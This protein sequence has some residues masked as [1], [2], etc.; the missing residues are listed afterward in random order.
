MKIE[1]VEGIFEV[2]ADQDGR[3]YIKDEKTDIE[4]EVKVIEVGAQGDIGL[5]FDS[6]EHTK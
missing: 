3:L 2:V 5:I 6:D 4:Y 1:N